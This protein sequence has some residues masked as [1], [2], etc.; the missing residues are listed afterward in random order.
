VIS[1]ATSTP[2]L[3]ARGHLPPA[4]RRW[5]GNVGSSPP[6]AANDRSGG[7]PVSTSL[8][9]AFRHVDSVRE[10][11][12]P[13]DGP[14]DL[15]ANA[16]ASGMW[17]IRVNGQ[18]PDSATQ[19]S[20]AQYAQLGGRKADG[21]PGS[22]FFA[23][24]ARLGAGALLRRGW[25]RALRARRNRVSV[26]HR[27]PGR[28]RSRGEARLRDITGQPDRRREATRRKSFKGDHFTGSTPDAS[29][30]GCCKW[31]AKAT[32]Q[33]ETKPSSSSRVKSAAGGGVQTDPRCRHHR[34]AHWRINVP[35]S[36]PFADQKLTRRI[37]SHAQS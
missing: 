26:Y 25:R 17:N 15:D 37:A 28:S 7:R 3:R 19:A 34:A 23:D 2:A 14:N 27:E 21:P 8:R 31:C 20:G 29:H 16:L 6:T 11:S 22:D 35:V 32:W 33:D 36:P 4:A 9:R 24:T 30:D 1:M 18:S 10:D 13:E 12:G 5:L